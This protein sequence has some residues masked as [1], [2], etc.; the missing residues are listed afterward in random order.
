MITVGLDLSLTSTGVARIGDYQPA[1]FTIPTKDT[2][3]IGQ[4]L[5]TIKEAIW[6]AT[7]SAD[8]VV[9]EDLPTHARGAGKTA[10][11]HGLIRWMLWRDDYDTLVVT[12]ATLK[13]FATGKGNA[14]KEEVLVAAVNR[15]GYTGHN[16]DEADALFLAHLGA[17]VLGQPQ[18]ELPKSHLRALD[19]LVKVAA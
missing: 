15:L 17:H 3:P 18:V 11:V 7:F 2:T 6:P 5:D 19:K 1:L 4:R 13:V 9:V 10:M 12:P 8:L 14:G 16:T